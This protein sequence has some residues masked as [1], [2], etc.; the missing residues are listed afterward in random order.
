MWVISQ[1]FSKNL[2]KHQ[3]IASTLTDRSGCDIRLTVTESKQYITTEGYPQSYL[4]D[5]DCSYNF[6]G[7]SGRKMLVFFEDVKLETDF[8][9]L[10]FRKLNNLCI[11]SKKKFLNTAVFA[12]F[13]QN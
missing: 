6:M 10:V 12:S 2:L 8:D 13:W 1:T 7:P 3:N 4:G 9:Y 11:F 5:Q